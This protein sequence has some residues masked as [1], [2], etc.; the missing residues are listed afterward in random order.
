M[1][2]HEDPTITL[3]PFAQKLIERGRAEGKAEG[4]AKGKV[5][6]EARMLLHILE[7]KFKQVPDDLRAAIQG[8]KE[9]ER[10]TALADV[11]V[12]VRSLQRFR[13]KADI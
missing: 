9:P 5:E 8:V 2:L 7:K 4:E 11:A 13:Q 3:P 10:L 12:S 6:G 1:E